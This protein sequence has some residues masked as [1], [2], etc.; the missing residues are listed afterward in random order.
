M[1][2]GSLSRLAETFACGPLPPSPSQRLGGC[3]HTGRPRGLPP[4]HGTHTSRRWIWDTATTTT[5][6]T[7]DTARGRR[8]RR[9]SLEPHVDPLCSLHCRPRTVW[10]QGTSYGY[11][12]LWELGKQGRG[13]WQGSGLPPWPALLPSPSMS[14]L[15]RLRLRGSCSPI[16]DQSLAYPERPVFSETKPQT[17]ADIL[18]PRLSTYRCLQIGSQVSGATKA[19]A[20]SMALLHTT[21]AVEKISI[22]EAGRAQE[23]VFMEGELCSSRLRSC[24]SSCI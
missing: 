24:V 18:T 8:P 1:V 10:G 3:P 22:N 21:D 6:C 12:A 4:S 15:T 16:S 11:C 9:G 14:R 20:S 19:T 13:G 17:I 7:V 2:S 23:A 5:A